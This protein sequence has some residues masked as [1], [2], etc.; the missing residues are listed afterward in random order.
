[1]GYRSDGVLTMHKNVWLHLKEQ[2]D[3]GV[4]DLPELITKDC[5]IYEDDD[6]VVIIE[7]NSL[8]MYD[9]YPEVEEFNDLLDYLDAFDFHEARIL[10]DHQEVYQY[11]CMGEEFEDVEQR[12][13]R[14]DF[15]VSRSFER[16]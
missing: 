16:Y 12:G 2:D 11:I 1:M 7:Y 6:E 14:C 4:R 5:D 15:F 9:S 13:D 3:S 10:E 8:K